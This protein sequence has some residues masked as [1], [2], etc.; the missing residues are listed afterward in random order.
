KHINSQPQVPLNYIS[1][2]V[3]LILYALGLWT[4]KINLALFFLLCVNGY[5]DLKDRK[6]LPKQLLTPP[7]AIADTTFPESLQ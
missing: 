6:I 4:A 2:I 5:V 3:E 7:G 1:I